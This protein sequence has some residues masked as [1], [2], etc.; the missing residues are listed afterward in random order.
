MQ[1]IEATALHTA[2]L[3]RRK[4]S[5]RTI[6]FYLFWLQALDRFLMCPDIGDVTLADLRAWIDS[7]IARNLATASVRGAGITVKVFLSWCARE[8]L[9]NSSPAGRLEL[10]Q[11][12]RRQPDPLTTNDLLTVIN[13][14]Q[15][16]GRHPARDTALVCFLA[17]TGCR[18]TELVALAIADVHVDCGY[19]VV[20]GKGNRQRAVFFG[21]ATVAA[22]EDWLK[23]RPKSEETLFGMTASGLREVLRRLSA[24]TGLHLTPHRFRRS[25]ATLRA[26]RRIDAP[27]LQ[28]MMGWTDL[29]TANAYVAATQ[30]AEAAARTHPL[31]GVAVPRAT[32]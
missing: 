30:V 20:L 23:V 25:A 5:P 19:A 31:T 29:V 10:P 1:L 15:C 13:S 3:R 14:I 4:R 8:E 22:L 7:L 11:R 24:K 6:E 16:G 9:I 18:R 21:E 27:A 12:V 17:E 2:A 32:T 26:A 28:S